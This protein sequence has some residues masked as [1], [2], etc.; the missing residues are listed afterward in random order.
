MYK[1]RKFNCDLYKQTNKQKY[2]FVSIMFFAS[3]NFLIYNKNKSFLS[4]FEMRV[5]TRWTF[6]IE[7]IFTPGLK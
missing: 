7:V 5:S 1:Y 6:S 2:L 4:D 3:V